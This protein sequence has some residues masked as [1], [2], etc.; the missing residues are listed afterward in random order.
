MTC[1]SFFLLS[2]VIFTDLSS[3]IIRLLSLNSEKYYSVIL[4]WSLKK[5]WKSPMH[6][7]GQYLQTLKV[8][9]LCL[10]VVWNPSEKIFRKTFRTTTRV[11]S[12]ISY[13]D[14]STSSQT[15]NYFLC[16]FSFLLFFLSNQLKKLMVT[17]LVENFKTE[18]LCCKMSVS[19]RLSRGTLS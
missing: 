3:A 2:T 14:E 6:Y 4:Y 15:F 12:K 17:G 16:I 18:W 11:W 7:V 10:Y 5:Y 19:K 13:G 9:L 1:I 8:F